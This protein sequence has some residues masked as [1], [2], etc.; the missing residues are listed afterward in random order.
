MRTSM[1]TNLRLTK[2]D[3]GSC[4][5]PILYRSRIGNLLYLL[6]SRHDIYFSVGVYTK[7]LA[8]PKESHLSAIKRIIW[9][10][11]TTINDVILVF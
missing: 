1:S 9:F 11:N 7:Y 6:V 8:N 10:V 5:D 4:V 3:S 2:G